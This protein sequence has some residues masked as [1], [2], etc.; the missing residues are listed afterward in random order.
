M[1]T[2]HTID[3]QMGTLA[4]RVR[5][6]ATLQV[7]MGLA[8]CGALAGCQTTAGG[9][10]GKADSV[11][12]AEVASSRC[13][14]LPESPRPAWIT[15]RPDTPD[16]VGV[17]QAGSSESPEKQIRAAEDDARSKLASEISVKIREQLIQNLCEGACGE[18]EQNKILIKTESKTKQTLKGARIQQRW[19]DRHN[20]LVWAWGTLPPDKVEF[21]RVMM[22]N[23]SPPSVGMAGLL[24][25]H[26]EK[27]LREDLAV[28]PADARLE[29]CAT[30]STK[31]ECQARANTIFGSVT[32]A[33]ENEQ[34]SGDGQFHQ[35]LFRATGRLRFQD[36][37]VSSFDVRCKARAEAKADAQTIDRAAA[38][39]CRNKLQTTIKK[40]L[41]LMD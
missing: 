30:D 23:L 41:E 36:R 19:L 5:S 34:T 11:D 32:V 40:D 3:G 25:G 22:F 31:A 6:D 7:L 13:D 18:E 27:V 24:V 15:H 20:C 9:A 10:M 12:S 33:L 28:V 21:R 1:R 26:L 35:R 38:E 14:F 17:G 4:G 29:G 37:E 8:L 39:A 2:P 16:Y